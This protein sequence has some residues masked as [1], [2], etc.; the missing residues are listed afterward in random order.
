MPLCLEKDSVISPAAN[1]EKS[2]G[3]SVGVLRNVISKYGL[4]VI[5]LNEMKNDLTVSTA[6]GQKVKIVPHQ[7]AWWPKEEV[8]ESSS[9]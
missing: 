5:R 4:G 7:P 1:I 3:K 9:G 6:D 8:S 2:T